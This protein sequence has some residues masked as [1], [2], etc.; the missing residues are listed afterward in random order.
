LTGFSNVSRRQ[1]GVLAMLVM[2]A[3][4]ASCGGG[5]QPLSSRPPEATSA[6]S[7]ALGSAW[8]RVTVPDSSGRLSLSDALQGFALT[9]GPVPRTSPPKGVLTPVFP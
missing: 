3:L 4:I 2:L 5:E 7:L 1:I 9:V 6:R 8:G